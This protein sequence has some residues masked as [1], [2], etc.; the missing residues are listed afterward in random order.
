MDISTEIAVIIP[1]AFLVVGHL[2]FRF[3]QLES[4]QREEHYTRKYQWE[5]LRLFEKLVFPDEKAISKD[6]LSPCQLPKE[7]LVDILLED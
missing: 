3:R 1:L 4:Q 6:D 2:Y 7:K 5:K